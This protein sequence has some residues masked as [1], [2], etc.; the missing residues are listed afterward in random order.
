MPWAWDFSNQTADELSFTQSYYTDPVNTGRQSRWTLSLIDPETPAYLTLTFP[1][2][3]SSSNLPIGKDM[4]FSS[5][6]T[7]SA[8]PVLEC[9]FFEKG[10]AFAGNDSIY[11]D[12]QFSTFSSGIATGSFTMQT[13]GLGGDVT[14]TNGH[15]S[16]IP[17]TSATQ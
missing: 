12:I 15:F 16:N 6:A 7:P 14:F 1:G 13:Y 4:I 2:I 11:L 3:D 17:V 10:E 9:S 8:A 5:S